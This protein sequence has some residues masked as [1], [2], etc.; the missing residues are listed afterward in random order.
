[1]DTNEYVLRK[2]VMACTG[3]ILHGTS[4]LFFAKAKS[5]DDAIL[6]DLIINRVLRFGKLLFTQSDLTEIK[7]STQSVLEIMCLRTFRTCFGSLVNLGLIIKVSSSKSPDYVVNLPILVRTLANRSPDDYDPSVRKVKEWNKHDFL[8]LADEVEKYIEELKKMGL[9][10][11][12]ETGREKSKKAH[13]TKVAK[14]KNSPTWTPEKVWITMKELCAEYSV[15]FHDSAW[16]GKTKGCV[17][18]WIKYC[19]EAGANPSERLRDICSRWDEFKYNALHTSGNN[20]RPKGMDIVL[21][22][23]VSFQEFFNNR[24]EIEQWIIANKNN[25]SSRR[26]FDIIITPTE[27]ERALVNG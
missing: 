18:H 23:V 4:F 7:P 16:T 1:M 19:E 24:D 15:P 14:K 5:K 22:D 17:K 26:T 6:L 8:I 10:E 12:V 27:R 13:A 20:G 11:A 3:Q 2:R 21:S 25:K 9:K